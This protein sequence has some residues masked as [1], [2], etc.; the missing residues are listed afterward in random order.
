MHKLYKLHNQ[1]T[2][3]AS[4]IGKSYKEPWPQVPPLSEHGWEKE[5]K[6]MDRTFSPKKCLE[7]PAPLA[8]I[9]LV[10]CDLQ[11]TSLCKCSD[12]HNIMNYKVT[13]EEDFP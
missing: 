3:L 6:N 9:E 13:R 4:R 7:L 8:V 12:C 11:C 1:R 10:K 2:H 5:R